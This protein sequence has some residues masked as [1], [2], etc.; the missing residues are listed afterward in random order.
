ERKAEHYEGVD[1]ED[2]ARQGRLHG[3]RS[4]GG[5]VSRT[6]TTPARST[7]ADGASARTSFFWR[8]FP[9]PAAAHGPSA[10]EPVAAGREQQEREE[11]KP[12]PVHPLEPGKT[13]RR[14]EHEP[15]PEQGGGGEEAQGVRPPP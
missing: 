2:Q 1:A 10:D 4:A 15:H 11:G 12:A 5:E 6:A 14:A 13:H 7:P 3:H 9:A 8:C